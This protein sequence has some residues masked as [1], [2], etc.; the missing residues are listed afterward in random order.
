[1]RD[2]CRLI[3]RQHSRGLS[4]AGHVLFVLLTVA[5]CLAPSTSASGGGPITGIVLLRP[6]ISV[7]AGK[8]TVACRLGLQPLAAVRDQLRDGARME[9]TGAI[10]LFAKRSLLPDSEQAAFPIRW[11]LHYAPLTRDFV[12]VSAEAQKNAVYRSHALEDLL[13][14][15]WG[16]LHVALSPEDPLAGGQEYLVRIALTLEYAGAPPWLEKALFFRARELAPPLV[17][18]QRFT[19]APE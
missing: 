6:D 12:L 2:A 9:L 4:P 14:E 3:A 10:T 13:R 1:M 18:E 7:D 19:F 11:I 8:V 17:F 15:A 16:S 5:M